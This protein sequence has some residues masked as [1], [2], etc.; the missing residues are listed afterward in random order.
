MIS[1]FILVLSHSI[2]DRLGFRRFDQSCCSL[3]ESSSICK[4]KVKS[5]ESRTTGRKFRTKLTV[6]VVLLKK[7]FKV[8]KNVVG[9]F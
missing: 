8:S 1:V 4:S 6:G 3:K 5:D 2:P 7:E 9:F